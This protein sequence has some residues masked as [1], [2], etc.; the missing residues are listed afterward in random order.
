MRIRWQW[1]KNEFGPLTSESW[2]DLDYQWPYFIVFW[3][4]RLG[5]CVEFKHKYLPYD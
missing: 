5:I 3:F 2:F 1:Y 4:N